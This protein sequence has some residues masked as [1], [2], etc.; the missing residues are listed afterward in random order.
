M[1][2]QFI[3]P[4]AV[5][6]LGDLKFNFPEGTQA[7]GRLDNHSEG[8]LILTT[9]KKIHRL[10]FLS[11]KP[12]KRTYL[13]LVR[14]KM[15]HESIQQLRE[16][17]SIKIKGGQMYTTLPCDVEVVDKPSDLADSIFA[18]DE[19]IPHTWLTISLTEGKY[20]QVRKMLAILKHPVRRLIRISI[21]D[22]ILENLKP[23][24][25]MELEEKEFFEKLKIG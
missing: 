20:H 25:V 5:N 3:S 23:G 14:N 21:E 17:V 1:V 15:S 16:G 11:E 8:L 12:H 18:Y 19:G 2:S 6:L 22:L 9:N 24:D 4:D 10:L 13:I 7:V